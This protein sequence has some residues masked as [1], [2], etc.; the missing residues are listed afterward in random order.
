MHEVEIEG[1]KLK[2]KKRKLI[3]IKYFDYKIYP[4]FKSK[5]EK[6]PN[7]FQKSFEWTHS[8]S[9]VRL[10]MFENFKKRHLFL[11]CDDLN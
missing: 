8:E 1:N 11:Y 5:I 9:I 4:N 7:D 10:Y 2:K 3:H 6:Y